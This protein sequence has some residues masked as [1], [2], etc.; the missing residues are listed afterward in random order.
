M[1]GQIGSLLTVGGFV[2][3]MAGV[4]MNVI[5]M[6]LMWFAPVQSLT[7]RSRFKLNLGGGVLLLAGVVAMA[8]GVLLELS[9]I[10]PLP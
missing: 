9:S 4:A 3:A 2:V 7:F 10:R 5:G 8:L 6:A 1:A